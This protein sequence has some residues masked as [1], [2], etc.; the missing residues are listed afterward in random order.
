MRPILLLACAAVMLI[1]ACSSGPGATPRPAT[2]GLDA[3]T[4]APENRCSPY[5][6]RDYYYPPSVEAE[7]AERDGLVSPYDGTRFA[8]LAESQIEHV[9]ALSEAHDSGLCA[10]TDETRRQFAADVDNL[11]LATPA[12]NRAK[13]G[14]DAAEWMPPMNA[15]WFAE[16]IVAVRQDYALTIDQAEADALR[17][18]LQD[19]AP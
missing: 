13:S 9:V 7:I 14:K 3:L 5:D 19:C 1:T 16:T 10:A 6:R 15:C 11:A 8:S 12:L 17:A 18:V 4:V 2:T